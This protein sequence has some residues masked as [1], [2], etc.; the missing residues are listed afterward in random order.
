[1]SGSEERMLCPGCLRTVGDAWR[2]PFAA[3]EP[4]STP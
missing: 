2:L 1:M 4:G 3:E